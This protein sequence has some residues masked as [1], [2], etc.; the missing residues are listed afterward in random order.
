M[1]YNIHIYQ[2]PMTHESRIFKTAKT[3][4]SQF[5]EVILLGIG[6]D[7]LPKGENIYENVKIIRSPL[8]SNKILSF[9][10]YYFWVI[11]QIF[12]F[13]PKVVTIHSLELLP[14]SIFAKLVSS[15]IV[16]DAHELETE[17]NG[18]G[19][20][21][22]FTSRVI[23]RIFIRFCD[24]T[25]VVGYEISEFYNNRY[26]LLTDVIL[27]IPYLNKNEFKVNDLF[28]NEFS[29]KKDEIIFLYQGLLGEG[30]GLRNLM[31]T[32]SKLE[33][34]SKKLVFMGYG[35]LEKEII[36]LSKNNENVF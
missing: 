35:P 15:N 6:K 4:C 1:N 20:L 16:Y 7:N 11:G 17:K 10:I 9:I 25:V 2:S 32:F 30:R 24:K 29:I 19:K 36:K 13:K 3:I 12:K 27:N 21:R 5:D 22:Q 14:L 8:L 34:V 31:K 33:S 26:N 28:R 23:E 18:M